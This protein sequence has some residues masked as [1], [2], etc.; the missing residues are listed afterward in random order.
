MP[1]SNSGMCQFF[2]SGFCQFAMVNVGFK[3]SVGSRFLMA[4]IESIFKFAWE[5]IDNP[6]QI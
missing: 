5:Y 6:L 1:W 4:K 3:I 2:V